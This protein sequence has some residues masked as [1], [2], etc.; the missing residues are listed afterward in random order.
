MDIETNTGGKDGKDEVGS[1][2]DDDGD[3]GRVIDG[4]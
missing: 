1:R 2:S 3:P 4:W